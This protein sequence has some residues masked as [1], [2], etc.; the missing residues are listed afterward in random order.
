M[1]SPRLPWDLRLGDPARTRAWPSPASGRGG[2]AGFHRTGGRPPRAR[3][4]ARG[5]RWSPARA[6]GPPRVWGTEVF[7]VA[8][9]ADGLRCG[10]SEEC[11]IL[12]IP[13]GVGDEQRSWRSILRTRAPTTSGS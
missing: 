13:F 1:G 11:A 7:G 5:R 4:G 9:V 8:R 12:V 6:W 10:R 2:A 3:P